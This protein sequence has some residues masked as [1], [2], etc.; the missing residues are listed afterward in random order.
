MATVQEVYDSSQELQNL[1]KDIHGLF[2]KYVDSCG[3]FSDCIAGYKPHINDG[4]YSIIENAGANDPNMYSNM[5]KALDDAAKKPTNEYTAYM[6]KVMEYRAKLSDLLTESNKKDPPKF[7]N[8]DGKSL[9]VNSSTNAPT[10]VSANTTA[11]D[12]ADAAKD[13]ADGVK[14]ANKTTPASGTNDTNPYDN[15]FYSAWDPRLARYDSFVNHENDGDNVIIPFASSQI[16]S[17]FTDLIFKGEKAAA[18]EMLNLSKSGMPGYVVSHLLQQG[19]SKIPPLTDASTNTAATNAQKN[20]ETSNKTGTQ[21][22]NNPTYDIGQSE[23][24]P[25]SMDPTLQYSGDNYGSRS[26]MNQYSL[27]KLMGGIGTVIPGV[28]AMNYMYDIRDRRRFYDLTVN[29]AAGN[30]PLSIHNPTVSNIIKWSNADKWGRTPYSYQDFVFNKWFGIIPNNRLITFRRYTVP[31]YDNLNFESMWGKIETVETDSNGKVVDAHP[32][33]PSDTPT[34]TF[35]P[36]ASVVSYF[37]GES[38]NTLSSFLNFTSGLKWRDLESKIHDVSG[39]EGEDPQQVVD[40]LFEGNGT[41]YGSADHSVFNG[42]LKNASLL[43]SKIMSFGKFG[44]S[45]NGS[46][47]QSEAVMMKTYNAQEDPY[48]SGNLFANRIQGPINRIQTTKARDAGIEFEQSFTLKVSYVGKAI[49]GINPKAALLDCLG[50]AME[51]VS[52]TAV[53]WGGG[54]RFMITPHTYPFH[55]GGWRGNF[56]EAIYNG[57]FL[58]NNGALSIIGSGIKKFAT[59][60]NTGEFDVNALTGSISGGIGSILGA[61]SAGLSAIGSAI[62]IGGIG[63]LMSS[64]ANWLSGKGGQIGGDA[65][66]NAGKTKFGNM[67]NNLSTMWHDRCL[68][69]TQF[70]TIKGMGALLSG[71]P[72]GEWHLTIGNPLNPIMV[73][74]NLICSKMQVEWDEELGPDDFP[75]GFTVT[76]TIEHGMPRD[77]D[78]IQSMFNRGMGRF[79]ALPDYVRMSSDLETSVDKYTGGSDGHTGTMAYK[80]AGAIKKLAKQQN[81][82][83]SGYN[84]VVVQGGTP[85]KTHG[86]PNTQLI[87]TFTPVATATTTLGN[88]RKQVFT[89]ESGMRPIIRAIGSIA[90]Q[91]AS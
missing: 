58:G 49:G 78:A 55:D 75:N 1:M 50:N 56:M 89:N 35:S 16:A 44:M 90:K 37:G 9:T 87:T 72:V 28:M 48:G 63:D 52:P 32:N 33:P 8:N 60:P 69:A 12:A 41:G 71:E 67:V 40:R 61:I 15:I 53:F 23:K 36:V 3:Q 65:A 91:S 85:L 68:Q 5:L 10:D 19:Q 74:G 64:A 51:M 7:N 22:V 45:I 4:T 43:S 70:P 54:H 25:I 47:G 34:G 2:N 11:K 82:P 81:V 88:L 42:M 77:K 6:N 57:K 21:N 39:D 13:V 24:I 31:C 27:T 38:G 80:N 83:T 17:A 73:C 14:N 26:I 18:Q 66:V 29:Q 62:G 79:Y 20:G 76:Y 30:D 86:N 46:F 84:K 59:N